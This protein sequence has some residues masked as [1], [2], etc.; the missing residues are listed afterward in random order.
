[1]S[2]LSDDSLDDYT[3][4]LMHKEM[5]RSCTIHSCLNCDHFRND[6]C[7]NFGQPQL[8]PPEVIVFGCLHW[9]V[10]VPF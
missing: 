2:I 9:E 3:R 7:N 8:P 10:Y 4:D 5:V 6:L 1:M